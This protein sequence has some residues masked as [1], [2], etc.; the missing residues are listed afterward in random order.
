MKIIV[1][2]QYTQYAAK[3]Y[4]SFNGVIAREKHLAL[5]LLR[6]GHQV[7]LTGSSKPDDP[8]PFATVDAEHLRLSEFDGVV[9]MPETALTWVLNCTSQGEALK[10]HRNVVA[11][12]DFAPPGYDCAAAPYVKYVGILSPE[13]AIRFRTP[14]LRDGGRLVEALGFAITLVD[15]QPNPW[16]TVAPRIVYTGAADAEIGK[17]NAIAEALYPDAELWI[18]ALYTAAPGGPDNFTDEERVRLFS[19]HVHFM[20][21]FLKPYLSHFYRT[22][23]R[24]HGQV[25]YDD[26]FPFLWH[27]NAAIVFSRFPGAYA[28]KL[29]PYLSCGL[30]TVIE[31]P[32][33]NVGDAQEIGAAVT[34]ENDDTVGLIAACRVAI[35]RGTEEEKA[36][37][38]K[39][40]LAWGT[41]ADRVKVIDAW[42]HAG[43]P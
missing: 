9:L 20:T 7:T 14:Y 6:L 24:R 8:P 16:S 25:L 11:W 39:D 43:L 31:L 28:S 10:Q 35:A 29:Y 30:P 34:V 15:D 40:A 42:L 5:E 21:D 33:C 2:G 12:C 41:W 36:Q 19:P 18:S 38:R 27:A 1:V 32:I 13:G 17:L 3:S 4:G 22:A 23:N 37:I 26:I